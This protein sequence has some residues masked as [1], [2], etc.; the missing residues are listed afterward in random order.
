MQFWTSSWN[1]SYTRIIQPRNSSLYYIAFAS[2]FI[3]Y[4]NL[5]L[6][7]LCTLHPNVGHY[8][9]F[10][11]YDICSFF[12]ANQHLLLYL[13]NLPSK[14]IYKTIPQRYNPNSSCKLSSLLYNVLFNFKKYSIVL[15]SLTTFSYSSYV[16]ALE[17]KDDSQCLYL[18]IFC[19]LINITSVLFSP[20]CVSIEF[21]TFWRNRKYSKRKYFWRYE[22]GELVFHHS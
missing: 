14:S 5:L 3:L 18:S 2:Y 17:D 13:P 20:F 7:T 15:F 1:H 12:S 11:F 6:Q 21:F 8:N 22:V 10:Y 4:Y 9:C 16:I 19:N